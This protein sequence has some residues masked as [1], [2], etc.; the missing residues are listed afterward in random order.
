MLGEEAGTAGARQSFME[1]HI[2]L[3]ACKYVWRTAVLEIRISSNRLWMPLE[4]FIKKFLLLVWRM[5]E[6]RENR[7]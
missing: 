5:N 2:V 4:S 6:Y 3:R 1:K 7:D